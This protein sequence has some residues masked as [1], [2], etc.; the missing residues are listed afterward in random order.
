MS[1]TPENPQLA[2]RAKPRSVRRFSRKALMGG[3]AVFGI[4]MFGALAIALQSPSYDDGQASEL[5][6]VTHKPMPDGLE[7]LPKSNAELKPKLGPPLPGD[8]GALI[9]PYYLPPHW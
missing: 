6:N 5:Y 4:V 1:N 7:Q 9:T 2:I 8:L 3:G